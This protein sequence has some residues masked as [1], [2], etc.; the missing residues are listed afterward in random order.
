MLKSFQWRCV[1]CCFVFSLHCLFSVSDTHTVKEEITLCFDASRIYLWKKIAHG[2]E[3]LWAHPSRPPRFSIYWWTRPTPLLHIF[4][5]LFFNLFYFQYFLLF[6]VQDGCQF[7]HSHPCYVKHHRVACFRN[8]K[9]V[10]RHTV[11]NATTGIAF[12]EGVIT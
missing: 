10:N 12:Q 4:L 3:L 1:K 11:Q 7:T 9:Q 8:C 6:C 2:A 5:C